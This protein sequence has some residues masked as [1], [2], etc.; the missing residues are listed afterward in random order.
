MRRAF[1]LLELLIV[2]AIVG[3]LIAILI[4]ALGAARRTAHATV[5]QSNLRTHHTGFKAYQDSNNGVMPFTRFPFRLNHDLLTPVKE[6]ADH[7]DAPM[8]R[9]EGDEII[10]GRPWTCPADR[11]GAAEWGWSYMYWPEPLFSYYE[12]D[13]N[14]AGKVTAMYDADPT[15][16]LFADVYPGHARVSTVEPGNYEHA[17]FL[18]RYDGSVERVSERGYWGRR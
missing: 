10:T 6:I 4:P 13:G 3:V 14:P 8:P 17:M 5:C 2:I 12:M 7:L 18:V 16:T 11:K 9:L 15:E 1:T